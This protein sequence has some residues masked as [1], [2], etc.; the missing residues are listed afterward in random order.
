MTA[1]EVIRLLK[2]KEWIEIRQTGSHKIFKNPSVR[3]N[4]SVPIHSG[5][6]IRK[7]TL[8]KILKEANIRL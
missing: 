1:K 3:N 4:I 8:R 6:D 2:Q 7:G 5:K